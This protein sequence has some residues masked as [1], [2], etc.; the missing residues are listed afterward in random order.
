MS[1]RPPQFR[2]TQLRAMKVKASIGHRFLGHS[3]GILG[4]ILGLNA[5]ATSIDPFYV[6]LF[7]LADTG[8]QQLPAALIAVGLIA[9]A[10]WLVSERERQIPTKIEPPESR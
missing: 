9:I 2:P 7:P 3:L 1:Q 10:A 8:I 4:A 5:I 6:R